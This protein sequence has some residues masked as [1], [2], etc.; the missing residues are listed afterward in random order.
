MAVRR[1]VPV[2]LD[3]TEGDADLLPEPIDQFRDAATNVGFTL[4]RRL[5]KASGGDAPQACV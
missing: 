1:T 4:L 5:P 2:E 3:V